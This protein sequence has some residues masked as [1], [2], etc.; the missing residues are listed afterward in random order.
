MPRRII[1]LVTGEF[2]HIF[3][4]S[5]Y[6]QPIFT[7]KKDVEI[8]DQLITYYTQIEP[9]VKFSY[10]KTNPEKYILNFKNRLVTII[11]YCWMP[12][13]FHISVR[14]D[15]DQGIQKFMQ[16]VLNSFSHYIRIKYGSKGSLLESAFRSV[17]DETN[18]QKM[19]LSRYQHINP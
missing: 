9:P 4:R 5:I 14:Q 10:Y 15:H 18:E 6:R 3:N 13:H 2:Y 1:P 12:N 7:R 17:L 8:F 11:S 19:H 16:R